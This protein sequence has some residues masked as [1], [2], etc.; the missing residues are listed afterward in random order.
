[1]KKQLNLAQWNR[2]EHFEFFSSFDEPFFGLVAPVDCTRT[3]AEAKRLGVPFFVYYLYHALQAA[4]QVEAFRYRIENGQVYQYDRVHASATIG[5]EDHT[6]GFSFIEQQD[7]LTSFVRAAA[8]EI[9]AVRT[10]EGLRLTETTG[11][12]DVIHFSALPWVRFSGL[13]HARSFG[14]PDSVP[15][16]SFGQTYLERGATLLPVSVNMHHGLADGYHVGQFLS[17]FQ[18]RLG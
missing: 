7:E 12:P 2:R 11:R 9:E 18:D 16:I 10:G 8:E 17:V 6:F 14:R 15:K 1:M 4:N 5:R 13:T 3:L